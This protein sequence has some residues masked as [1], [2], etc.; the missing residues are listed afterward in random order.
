L[1]PEELR[2]ECLRLAQ[3]A[4]TGIHTDKSQV[5]ERARTYADFVTGRNDA[6]I[7]GAAR[8]LAKKVAA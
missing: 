7:V 3:S 2:L 1:T 5:V 6:E 4:T 8:E